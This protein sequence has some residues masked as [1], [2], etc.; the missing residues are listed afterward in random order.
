MFGID[1]LVGGIVSGFTNDYFK[2]RDESRQQELSDQSWRMRQSNAHQLEVEDL[3]NAGLNPILSA[4][5]GGSMA[6]AASVSS[7]GSDSLSSAAQVNIA[8]KQLGIDQQNADNG[9]ISAKANALNADTQKSIGISTVKKNE[10]D[11]NFVI[12]QALNNAALTAQQISNMK[13]E[14]AVKQ[15][16]GDAQVLNLQSSASAASKNAESQ[17]IL[18]AVA[19]ENGISLRDLNSSQR[20]KIERELKIQEAKNSMYLSP[21]GDSAGKVDYYVRTMGDLLSPLFNAIKLNR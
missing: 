15:A 3:K 13:T 1:D 5:N 10:A 17:S 7:S 21:N 4:T 2:D 11:T 18:A 20:N 16:V 6:S 19:R 12:Q 14:Q 9:T 8:K